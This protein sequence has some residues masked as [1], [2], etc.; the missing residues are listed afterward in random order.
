[1]LFTWLPCISYAVMWFPLYFYMVAPVFLY[2]CS[3][4]G[5]PVFLMRLRGSPCVSI[6]LPVCFC[7]VSPMFLYGYPCVSVWFPLCF[8]MVSLRFYMASPVFLYGFPAFFC[9]LLL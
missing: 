2:G 1:L 4:R 6:W 8:S 3:L 7:M 9:G 5:S